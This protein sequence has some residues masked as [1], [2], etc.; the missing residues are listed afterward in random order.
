MPNKEKLKNPRKN[1][2]KKAKYKI[3]N[4]NEYNESLKNRGKLSLYFPRGDIKSQFINEMPYV[5]GISGQ[6]ETYKQPYIEFIYTLYVLFG[7]G[8]RILGKHKD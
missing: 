4:W 8:M 2:G 5:K 6:F 1:S 3:I 7:W